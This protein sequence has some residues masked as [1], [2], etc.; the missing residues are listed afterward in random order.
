[1]CT[2]GERALKGCLFAQHYGDRLLGIIYARRL[3]T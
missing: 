2:R 3:H 1:M